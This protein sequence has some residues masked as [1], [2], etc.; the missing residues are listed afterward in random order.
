MTVLLQRICWNTNQWRGPT[1][2]MYGKE[3]SYVGQYGFGHEEWNLN[4]SDLLAGKAFGY[5]YYNPPKGSELIGQAHDIF[6][7]AISPTRERRLVGYYDGAVFLD[8]AGRKKLKDEF[9]RSDLLSKR[10]EELLSLDLPSI[11]S[12]KDARSLLLDQFSANIVVPVK[13]VHSID[14]PPPLTSEML[15]GREPKYL[16]RYTTPVFLTSR[17]VI[18]RRN[19]RNTG[20]SAGVSGLLLED[21]YLRF[22]KAQQKVVLRLHNQ[23]SNRFRAWLTAVG[24]K[25][26]LAE[27]SSVDVECSIKGKRFLFELK[28]CFQQSTKHAIRDAIGQVLE[29]SHFPGRKKPYLS[30]IVLDTQPSRDEIEWCKTL[31]A[32]GL[33]IELFWLK[34]EDVYSAKIASHPLSPFAADVDY[35]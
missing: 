10:I 24:V 27:T 14:N 15:G 35:S 21:A 30:A 9:L 7:F 13:N 8:E 2:D 17:P 12:E 5:S 3:K 34:G 25:R 26:S 6:F 4:A 22:T 19:S 33:P 11:K 16:S 20:E 23:L 32:G 28:T 18:P 1:G 31:V 29:Y